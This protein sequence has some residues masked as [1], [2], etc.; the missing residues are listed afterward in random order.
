MSRTLVVITSPLYE[1][2]SFWGFATT[3]TSA[4]FEVD[5]NNRVF[6]IRRDRDAEFDEYCPDI[7]EELRRSPSSEV[8]IIIH[9]A[10]GDAKA[11]G[12]KKG[13][14][15]LAQ[16][17][18]KFSASYSSTLNGFWD[19]TEDDNGLPYN[20]F[21]SAVKNGSD[22]TAAFE[23]VWNFFCDQ[24]L[25]A[26]LE[27][28]QNVLDGESQREETLA[29]LREE[30]SGFEQSYAEFKKTPGEDIFS[31]AYQAAFETFRDALEIE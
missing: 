12:V 19:G 5:A 13:L 22:R 17:K 26:K 2:E 25:E 31:P 30:L 23:R 27:L 3:L 8:G 18:V 16:E 15:P 14:P 1:F 11:R 4:D 29:L 10:N 28:L 9:L 20:S 21:R 7:D 24:L 6:L